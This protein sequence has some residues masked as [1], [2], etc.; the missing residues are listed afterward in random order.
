MITKDYGLKKKPITTKNPQANAI[1]EQIHSTI[2][3]MIRTYKAFDDKSLDPSLS[4]PFKGILSAV[5]FG[6]RSTMHTTLQATPAQLVFGQDAILNIK[7]EAEWNL[8]KQRKQKLINTNNQKENKSRKNYV[9]H[10]GQQV[11]IEHFSNE[12]KFAADPWDGPYCIRQINNNNGT[13]I[14]Y[15]DSV[16]DTVNI[17]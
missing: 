9:Y 3:N 14:V 16:L 17:H 5:M 1:L 15:K 8:I 4:E 7:F 6:V 11:L 12:P 10:V 13:V 2:G